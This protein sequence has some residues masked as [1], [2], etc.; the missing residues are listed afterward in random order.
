VHEAA[1]YASAVAAD[2]SGIPHAQVAISLAQVEAGSLDLAAAVL[3][4]HGDGFVERLRASPYLSRFPTSL[5]PSPFPRTRRYA[6]ASANVEPLPD[7][8]R[9][10]DA[11]LVYITF[12][13]VLGDLPDAVAAY[14]SILDA[15]ADLPARVLFTIGRAIEPDALGTPPPTCTSSH[16]YRRNRFCPRPMSS[17]R[18]VAQER[19]SVLS[20]P[21]FRW[22]WSR[23]SPTSP[24]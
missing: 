22:S 11:P 14:R 3:A 13:T 23:S 9:E 1:E 15:V 24:A 21:A 18:T 2:R 12:G 5:D 6:E 20:R 19:P 8:W 17:W 4:R 10:S 16:G 7:W